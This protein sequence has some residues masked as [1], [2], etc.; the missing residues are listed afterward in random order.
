MKRS[1]S[2]FLILL[3]RI[4]RIVAAQQIAEASVFSARIEL[5]FSYPFLVT[6]VLMS[7]LRKQHDSRILAQS[8]IIAIT[9]AHSVVE[10]LIQTRSGSQSMSL[11]PRMRFRSIIAPVFLVLTWGLAACGGG[12]NI[13][14]P[15]TLTALQVSPGSPSIVLGTNQQFI[16]MGTFSDGSKQDLTTTA[17]WSSSNTAVATINSSGLATSLTIGRVQIIATSGSLRDSTTL[18]AVT[19][20]TAGVPRFAYVANNAEGTISAYTLNPATGQ[21]RSNGYVFAGKLPQGV[22]V[23]PSDRFAYVVNSGDN[24]IS[25]FLINSSN[26]ALTAVTGSPFPTGSTDPISMDVDPSGVFA[27]VANFGSNNISAFSID[28]ATGAL[29]AVAGSPFPTGAGPQSIVTDPFGKFVYVTNSP[30]NNVTGYTIDSATGALT[31][32]AGSPFMAGSAP[33]AVT[34]DGSGHF[35]YVANSS[36]ADVSEFSIDSATGVLT[37]LP[38]SPV[39]TGAGMEI[40]GLT[41]DPSGK[42]LYVAN[43]G[44]SSVSAFTINSNGGLAAI[45]GSPF[46][47]DSEPR[48]IQIDPTGKFAYVPNLSANEVEVFSIGISGALSITSTVRT[49]PQAAALALSVGTAAVTYT[50]KFAYVA[51]LSSN[52]VSS[53]IIDAVAGGLT[54][55]AGS[56]FAAGTGPF[57]VTADPQGKFV[58]V[59]NTNSDSVSA[60][61]VDPSTGALLPVPG[62]PFASGA[63]PGVPAVDPSGRFLYV[64]N[65]GSTNVS[66]YDIDPSTGALAAIAG[67]PFP[68]ADEPVAVGVDPTGRFAYVA[69]QGGTAYGV[70]APATPC[71]VS[72]YAIDRLTGALTQIAGSPFPAGPEP[73]GVALDPSGKFFYVA[74]QTTDTTWEFSI[75]A[76]TGALTNIG[77]TPPPVEGAAV[78]VTV[79]PTGRF[80]YVVAGD[81]PPPASIVKAYSIDRTFGTLS[82][83]PS[84]PF[85]TGNIPFSVAT[86]LSGRFLYVASQGDGVSAYTVDSAS[87][88]LT[89]VIGSPFLAGTAPI[90]VTTT[91]KI[92]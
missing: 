55:V 31:A 43:F 80:A 69:N 64:P 89:P 62:S 86:D 35:A 74:N 66:A 91:G 46:P 6:G 39:A 22:V 8:L 65:F 29:T 49:R 24:T 85:A 82:P 78:A 9:L 73:S 38:G 19:S 37:A 72:A 20:Q 60:Y 79:D 21:L 51:N 75:D 63:D 88:A 83:I 48:S 25:A 26:G 77:A 10:A 70:C 12:S 13:P 76:I 3:P 81:G 16:A 30:A 59:T 32:V 61:S 34:V 57:G 40:A 45:T 42:F 23:D 84:S 1:V 56:P 44:S 54:P 36:S 50:P 92:Q 47:V 68:A 41:V 11:N 33:S 71:G 15:K 14:Q 27:Y 28:A 2:S 53:Y 87:G 58:Y 5:L 17:T 90:S 4:D 7:K 18:I 52:S 67:S